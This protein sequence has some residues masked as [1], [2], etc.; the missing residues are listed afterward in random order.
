[1]TVSPNTR[2]PVTD[3]TPADLKTYPVWEF[4]IDEETLPGRDETWVRPIDTRSV[5]VGMY[6][7][8][9]ATEFRTQ[10]G[11]TFPGFSIVTT[12]R[13]NVEIDPAIILA[14]GSYLLIDD[15]DDLLLR[16]GLTE[17]EFY[18]ATFELRVPIDGEPELRGGRLARQG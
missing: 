9:V 2:K 18:P 13:G 8:P 10:C 17:T 1:M 6:S 16:T 14:E 11:R 5:P 3:L 15:P 12:A 4:A 7:M